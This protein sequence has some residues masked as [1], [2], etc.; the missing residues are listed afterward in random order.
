MN[1]K[2]ASSASVDSELVVPLTGEDNTC[3]LFSV[4][5][6]PFFGI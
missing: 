2:S 5:K 6:C 4:T 1:T 3:Y